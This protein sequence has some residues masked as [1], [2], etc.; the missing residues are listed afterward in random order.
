MP[1]IMIIERLCFTRI[2]REHLALITLKVKSV[3]PRCASARPETN[4]QSNLN[5]HH[6]PTLNWP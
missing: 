2:R 5:L 3:T 4:P 1:L 6:S